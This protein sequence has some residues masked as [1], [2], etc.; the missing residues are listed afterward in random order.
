M[1]NTRPTV[2]NVSLNGSIYQNDAN[3]VEHDICA[4]TFMDTPK[5]YLY[6]RQYMYC[7]HF[8]LFGIC[9][10]KNNNKKINKNK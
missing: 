1:E 5:L 9:N 10:K 4:V 2:L 8:L 3:P 7:L 6:A